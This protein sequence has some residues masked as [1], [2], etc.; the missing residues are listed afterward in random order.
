M[1]ALRKQRP[2]TVKELSIQVEGL[3]EAYMDLQQ[4]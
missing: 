4:S 3:L 1:E 2:M